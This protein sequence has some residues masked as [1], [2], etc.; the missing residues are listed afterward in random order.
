[1]SLRPLLPLLLPC[2]DW[3][4]YEADLKDLTVRNHMAIEDRNQAQRETY[5]IRIEL[6]QALT[7]VE[8]E[9]CS[10]QVAEEKLAKV[11]HQFQLPS[12]CV[13]FHVNAL[14]QCTV[15]RRGS[16]ARRC[17]KPP[18]RPRTRFGFCFFRMNLPA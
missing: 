11:R 10:A 18:L 16:T 4:E 8:Q 15:H 3:Q 7:L 12:G 2:M 9:S 14:L 5:E 13:A 1:M 6:K 17:T